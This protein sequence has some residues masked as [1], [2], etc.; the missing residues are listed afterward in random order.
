VVHELAHVVVLEDAGGIAHP[1][2]EL[3]HV[4]HFLL[5][6][7]GRARVARHEAGVQEKLIE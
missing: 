4:L 5:Q 1:R 7:G 3:A 6:L 2:E